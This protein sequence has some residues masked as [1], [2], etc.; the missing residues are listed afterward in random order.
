M[1][2]RS[3]GNRNGG[4]SASLA[5]APKRILIHPDE[6]PANVPCNAS[7]D[8]IN[9]DSPPLTADEIDQQLVKEG[10][11]VWERC[12]REL[13]EENERLGVEPAPTPAPHVDTTD[14]EP[15]SSY[16]RPF[17]FSDDD[18][19]LPALLQRSDGATLL[20]EG[21]VNFVFGSPSSGKSFF[22]EYVIGE[23]LMRGV[24]CLWWDFEDSP[25]TFLRRANTMG[26]DI[27]AFWRDGLFKYIKD[28]MSDSD[29]AMREA[30]E[31]LSGGD[32]PGLVV[33][34]AAESSGAPSDGADVRPWLQKHLI[35]PKNLGNTVLVADHVG[36][37]R[38][39]RPLG[40]IGSQHKL[41]FMDAG[42]YLEG[43]PWTTKLDGF[44]KIVVHKDRPGEMPAPRGKA[45]ARLEAKHER[46]GLYLSLVPPEQADNSDEAWEPTL[47]ALAEI[48]MSGVHGQRAMRDLVIG[49]VQR[50]DALV[51]EL[52]EEGMVSKVKDGNKMRYRIT[53]VGLDF[54]AD[55]EAL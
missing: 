3:K 54:L 7:W 52:V 37:H 26:M 23:T 21:K 19:P 45:V 14:G 17:D 30:M 44:V 40:P 36:K 38:E 49:Q 9:G 5:A 51:R 13:E 55:N 1:D 46:G 50:R 35:P 47:R 6:L 22:C 10:F 8:A 28:D 24:R 33:V 18:K 48:G 39:G 43:T 34:D 20:Y 42:L 29:R 4:P 15:L 27:K 53:Q 11:A 31:W 32:G 25:Q 12:L 2:D 41:A 16:E